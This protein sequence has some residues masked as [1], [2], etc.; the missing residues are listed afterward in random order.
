MTVIFPVSTPT[1]LSPSILC[2][3]VSCQYSQVSFAKCSAA[4]RVYQPQTY[5]LSFKCTPE[6]NSRTE[7]LHQLF[8]IPAPVNLSGYRQRS[9]GPVW[10]AS[11]SKEPFN[12]IIT[13]SSKGTTC[14]RHV[15]SYCI[16]QVSKK[17]ERAEE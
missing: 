2:Q 15:A 9:S 11:A 6:R 8:A 4:K 16:D 5:S 1:C 12:V 17:S 10:S 7:V 13:G 14:A 3:R